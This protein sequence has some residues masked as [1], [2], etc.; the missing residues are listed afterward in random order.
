MPSAPSLCPTLSDPVPPECACSALAV[1]RPIAVFHPSGELD[2]ISCIVGV[3]EL[4]G[5]EPQVLPALPAGVLHEEVQGGVW[6][7]PA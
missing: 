5:V 6:M 2:H 7:G 1:I 4:S 3:A